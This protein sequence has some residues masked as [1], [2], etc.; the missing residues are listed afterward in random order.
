MATTSLWHI[1]GKL[2]NLID[3]VENPDKTTAE[4][5]GMQDLYD[6]ISYVQ[7]PS[8]TDEK[9][10]ITTLNCNAAFALD[11]MIITKMRFGKTDGYM[12]WHGYQSFKPDELTA[13]ECHEI[14]VEMARELWGDKFQVI[15]TTHIDKDHLHNH[16][17]FNSVSFKDG[18]RYNYSKSERRRMM[19]ISDRLCLEHG[20]SVI[21][22]PHK[23]PSR[24]VWLDEKSGKPTRYNI[25]KADI[26]EAIEKSNSVSAIEKYLMRKGYDVDLSGAHCKIK[27]P[28]YE[29][30][31]RMDTVDERFTRD[32][33]PFLI[34]RTRSWIGNI[35]AQITY[36]PGMPR[37]Y[38][39]KGFM[40]ILLSGTKVYKLYLYYCYQLGVLPKGT[41]YKPTSPFLKEALRKVDEISIHISYI[42]EHKI[43]TMDDLL[44]DRGGIE[45]E[46]NKLI[47][48]RRALQ[49][50]IR[51][52]E[53][54]EK[55]TLR[56]EKAGVTAQITGFRKRMNINKAIETKSTK[57]IDDIERVYLNEEKARENS[58]Q[59]GKERSER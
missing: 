14:G 13:E 40:D 52:A 9:R 34:Q 11:Q 35:P 31:T 37:E 59:K 41:D 22:K 46:M 29:Y 20:L 10:Y 6:V 26:I 50:K 43:E 48:Q 25:Y 53:P 44:R 1:S 24:P 19:E 58:L 21:K 32:N 16:F 38:K 57:M 51:R 4:T 23:A 7:R 36:P 18:K 27:L 2:K 45:S 56:E 33:I 8:A 49:N 28:Q 30:Y 3:Y 47:D 17:C 55:A 15:V 12:A 39:Q 5:K 42:S 54:E